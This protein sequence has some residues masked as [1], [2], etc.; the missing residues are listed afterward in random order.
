MG[1]IP[2]KVIVYCNE[3]GQYMVF[4]SDRHGFNNPDEIWDKD[5]VDIVA[6]GDSFAH[7]ACM[8]KNDG[9]VSIIR[10]KYPSIINLAIGGN[11]PQAN[12]AAMKEYAL[13]KKPRYILWFHFAGNDLSGMMS[14]KDHP[15][16]KKYV[17]EDFFSEF[18]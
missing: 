2:H 16:Y 10:K 12:L 6:L 3:V 18:D 5:G 8:P 9:F 1:N 4:K 15:I 13:A 14:H 17:Y 7:G 11:N